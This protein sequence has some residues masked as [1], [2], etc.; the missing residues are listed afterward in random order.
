MYVHVDIKRNGLNVVIL[1]IYHTIRK[2]NAQV[3]K[4]FHL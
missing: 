3:F 2:Y 4:E 1:I